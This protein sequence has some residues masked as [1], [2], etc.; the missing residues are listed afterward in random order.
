MSDNNY[1]ISSN[2]KQPRYLNYNQVLKTEFSERIQKISIN[3]GFTCPNRD[4]SKD[5]GGCTYCNNQSFSPQYSLPVKS[6]SQQVVEGIA[7]FHHKY[8][9]QYYLAYFQS[10]TNT[11]DALENL[12]AIYEEALSHPQVK[13]IV[14]GTRPDCVNEKL[15]DYFAEL[16][17][18]VYVMIEYG[19]ESTSDETLRFINRGHNY[20]SSVEAI[21]A[22]SYRGLRTG[23]HLILGLPNENREQIL[24]HADKISQLPLTALKLHQLQLV[25]KTVMTK[26]FSEHPE[27]FNLYTANEYIDL[28]IDFLERMNPEIA[29][30]RF[31]SQSP[32]V[33]LIAPE[34]GL[35]NFEFTAKIEK[36]LEE[37]NTW[38]GRLFN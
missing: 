15:L 6:V 18:S 27:W 14:V 16:S 20:A 35:K 8:Q 5:R 9:T 25:K 30:E 4:G 13:G 10:Y 17:K 11:Y 34:W 38:Q 29:I 19:I 37:R 24:I 2:L 1:I 26:Q 28:A 23:A 7:F 32:K 36:R 33:L 12:K 21:K 22:T 31:V 3:A